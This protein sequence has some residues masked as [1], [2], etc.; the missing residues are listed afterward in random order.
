MLGSATCQQQACGMLGQQHLLQHQQH[1]QQSQ[2]PPQGSDAPLQLGRDQQR[3]VDAALSG[4]CVFVTGQLSPANLTS[5][6]RRPT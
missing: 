6:Q 1:Q 3:A 5:L 2:H 4:R